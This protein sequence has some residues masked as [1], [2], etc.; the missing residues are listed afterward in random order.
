M[1]AY[2]VPTRSLRVRP[3]FNLDKALRLTGELEDI[4]LARAMEHRTKPC[5]TDFAR[6]AGLRWTDP[7]R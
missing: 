3:G 5:D 7:L 4:R 1:T 2:R 6:F